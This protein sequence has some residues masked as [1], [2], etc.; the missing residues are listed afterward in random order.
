MDL[1]AWL[2]TDCEHLGA[3]DLDLGLTEERL[4]ELKRANVYPKPVGETV[5]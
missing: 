5:T 4:K 2:E 1:C 3:K